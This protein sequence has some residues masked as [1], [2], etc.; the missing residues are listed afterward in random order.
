MGRQMNTNPFVIGYWARHH[1]L[2][3]KNVLSQ[4]DLGQYLK[5]RDDRRAF[6]D[7]WETRKFEE[8]EESMKG[9]IKSLQAVAE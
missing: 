3:L 9:L 2:T 7:G 4:G 6:S 1:G 5:D 8:V